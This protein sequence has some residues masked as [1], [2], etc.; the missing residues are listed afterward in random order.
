MQKTAGLSIMR[1][2]DCKRWWMRERA[3]SDIEGSRHQGQKAFSALALFYIIESA[4]GSRHSSTS[5]PRSA[6][7]AMTARGPINIYCTMLLLLGCCMMF[8]RKPQKPVNGTLLRLRVLSF[9]IR[10][11]SMNTKRRGS[12]LSWQQRKMPRGY[13]ILYACVCVLSTLRGHFL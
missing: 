5:T 3:R 10:P 8:D 9:K 7:L 13:Y 2:T 6:Q 1:N 11:Q 4:D 12:H